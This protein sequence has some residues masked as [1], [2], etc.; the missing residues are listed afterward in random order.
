MEYTRADF[1]PLRETG[2]G[3]GFT[4]S[5]M[6]LPH[7]GNPL[8]FPE[9]VEAF[10]VDA[11]VDQAAEAGAGHVL[12]TTTHAVHHLP[13]P[14]PVVDE[15]IPGR[16]CRRDLVME[17]ADALAA[18]GIRLVLYYHHGTDGK[19]QDPPWQEAVGAMETDQGRFYDNYCRIVSW[20]G[21][22]YGPKATAFWFDAAYGL[23]GRGNPDRVQPGRINAEVPWERMTAAAK[24]GHPGRLVCY[25]TGIEDY[26][27]C[28][29]YQDYWAGELTR[30]NFVP[31]GRKTPGGL[32]WYA[33]VSWHAHP[34]GRS[35]GEWLIHDESIGLDWPAP[36]A[37][38]VAA[39]IRRFRG[40]GGAVTFNLLCYQD[41]SA[42]ETDLQVMK[43][44][45]GIL[46]RS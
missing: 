43:D 20:M 10:D 18:K 25:N 1:A 9:A 19:F 15:I 42:L 46:G 2:Y 22:H 29:E 31:R 6:T 30:L 39:L 14:H 7:T 45:K 36:Q 12:F 28:T 37:E 5:A 44:V 34:L 13:F 3:I 4:W 21:E 35:W 24:T 41:G 40:A 16:T 32:A 38:S 11:F 27:L 17:M 33:Y 8:P 23:E 26:R